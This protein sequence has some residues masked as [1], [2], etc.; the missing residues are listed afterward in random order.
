LLA[1]IAVRR[2]D[3]DHVHMAVFQQLFQA[4]VAAGE[5]EACR[6]PS[7][8]FRRRAESTH[9]ANAEPAQR[10]DVDRADEAGTDDGR[11]DLVKRSHAVSPLSTS[12]PPSSWWSIATPGTATASFLSQAA[13]CINSSVRRPRRP[14]PPVP[15]FP[16]VGREIHAGKPRES[17]H[18]AV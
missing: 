1:V 12:P 14:D 17:S 11:R 18:Q 3:M 4:G 15:D 6:R 7:R 2:G 9:Y 13:A 16:C 5:A 10:L 8:L